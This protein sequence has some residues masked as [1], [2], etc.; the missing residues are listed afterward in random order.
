M[1]T[2]KQVDLDRFM[3]DWYVIAN[4][5]TFV[6]KGAY[7]AVESYQLNPD[8]SIATT[9]TFNKDAFDGPQ[10]VYHP[11]GFVLDTDSNARWGMQFIWPIKADYRIVYLDEDYQLTVIARAKRDYV[12]VMARSPEFSDAKLQEMRDFIASIGYDADKLQR[13]PQQSDRASSAADE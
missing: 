6:E 9:F 8:G 1:D 12:W 13:V 3:G 10:K 7:N 11:T 4:I 5:P 2:V